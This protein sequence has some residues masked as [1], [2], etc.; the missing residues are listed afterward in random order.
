MQSTKPINTNMTHKNILKRWYFNVFRRKIFH[1]TYRNGCNIAIEP[2]YIEYLTKTSV[3]VYLFAKGIS[4]NS[5]CTHM[6]D[7]I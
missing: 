3:L 1:G 7:V 5:L 6:H 2:P 4:S